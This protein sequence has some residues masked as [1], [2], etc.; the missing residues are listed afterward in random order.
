MQFL[1]VGEAYLKL[2]VVFYVAIILLLVL[3]FLLEPFGIFLV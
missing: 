3:F 1:P 2:K